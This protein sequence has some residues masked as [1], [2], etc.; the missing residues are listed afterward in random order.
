MTHLAISV[1]DNRQYEPALVE[2]V[3]NNIGNTLSTHAENN[4][5]ADLQRAQARS[6]VERGAGFFS[7]GVGI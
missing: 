5:V 3:R 2:A 7:F 6:G 4:L 1:A